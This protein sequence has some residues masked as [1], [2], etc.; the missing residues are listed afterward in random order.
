M[1]PLCILFFSCCL[2]LTVQAQETVVAGKVLNEN[3][4]PVGGA[5][6]QLGQF[7]STTDGSGKFSMK[8]PYLPLLL[9]VKHPFYKS[10]E[11]V[12]TRTNRLNDT[13]F[14]EIVLEE[15]STDLDEV[16]ISSD[17]VRWVYP[18][19]NTH[20]IDFEVSPKG[21][22]LLCKEKKKYWLR[23]TDQNDSTLFELTIR[24]H[25]V[26][27]FTDCMHNTHVVYRDSSYQI[28]QSG[29]SLSLMKGLLWQ[30]VRAALYPCALEYEGLFYFRDYGKHNQIANFT[31]YDSLTHARA[32]LYVAQDRKAMRSLDEYYAEAGGLKNG[33][34]I[35]H[36]TDSASLKRARAAYQRIVFYESVLS[37]TPYIPLVKLEDSVYLFDHLNDSLVVFSKQGKRMRSVGIL[38]HLH[39][40]WANEIITDQSQDRLFAKLSYNGMVRLIELDPHTGTTGKETRLEKHIYPTKIQVEGNFVYYLFHHYIDD[41]INYIYKQPITE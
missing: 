22:L 11:Q 28:V 18:I 40:R 25:P 33:E 30:R 39:P 8:T 21:L 31:T 27:F 2:K 10:Y 3:Q 16:V 1:K 5:A 20:I 12:V 6:V 29:D 4:Q 38:H 19:K 36:A 13:V 17:R 24:E 23:K 37:R 7:F 9:N 41:S 14:L 26:S 32:P 35:I 15:K 34:E